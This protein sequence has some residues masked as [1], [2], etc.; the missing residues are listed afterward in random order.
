[1]TDN[2]TQMRIRVEKPLR[3]EEHIMKHL[4][5]TADSQHHFKKLSAA[6]I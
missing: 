5:N 6:F 4:S 3:H 2:L 1:M